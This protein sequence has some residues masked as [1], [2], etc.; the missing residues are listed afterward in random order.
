[1]TTL[2]ADGESASA[3]GATRTAA[4]TAATSAA[5]RRW[6]AADS[7]PPEVGIHAIRLDHSM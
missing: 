3:V 1:V 5:N 7:I 6:A 2:S 4:A